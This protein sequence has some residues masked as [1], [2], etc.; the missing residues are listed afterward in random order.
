MKKEFSAARF[1]VGIE[2]YDNET[3]KDIYNEGQNY[4]SKYD[5]IDA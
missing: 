2:I 1:C 3:Q 4:R 5:V